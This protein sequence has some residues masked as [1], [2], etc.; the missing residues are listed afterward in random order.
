MGWRGKVWVLHDLE[1][2]L[3]VTEK[4]KDADDVWRNILPN[5]LNGRTIYLFF[6]YKP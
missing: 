4:V 6:N 1:E 3:E 2:A 5:V